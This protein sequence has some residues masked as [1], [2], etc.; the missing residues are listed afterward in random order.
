[1][2]SYSATVLDSY[3]PMLIPCYAFLGMENLICKL[4]KNDR[5]RK[6][7]AKKK[8]EVN[9]SHWEKRKT[10]Y[11]GFPASLNAEKR[12]KIKKAWAKWVNF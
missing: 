12:I 10:K 6:P 11:R 9:N 5:T 3:I 1:M 4:E 8:H 2:D 7:R